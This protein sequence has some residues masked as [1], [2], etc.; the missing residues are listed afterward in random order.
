MAAVGAFFVLT[1]RLEADYE[2]GQT[3]APLAGRSITHENQT[4]FVYTEENDH[5]AQW[6]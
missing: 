1:A 6:R 4:F 5:D 3:M 2:I